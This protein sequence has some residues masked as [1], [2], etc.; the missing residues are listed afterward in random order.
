MRVNGRLVALSL[1]N[2]GTP[3]FCAE[4]AREGQHGH[5]DVGDQRPQ[6]VAESGRAILL[7][8]KMC[9]PG[10]PI[11]E[12]QRDQ[13]QPW[14][15]ERQRR[16]Q[17]GEGQAGAGNVQASSARLRVLADNKARTRNSA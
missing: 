9:D 3:Q 12:Q 4:S 6:R 14:I 10:W 16:G 11:T 5:A 13:R 2:S 1:G 17:G 15:S 7:D 8:R